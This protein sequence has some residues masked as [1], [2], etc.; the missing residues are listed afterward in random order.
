MPNILIIHVWVELLSYGH[1]KLII[2]FCVVTGLHDTSFIKS[3][4]SHA[5]YMTCA[6]IINCSRCTHLFGS[7][8]F[9][10]FIIHSWEIFFKHTPA[11]TLYSSCLQLVCVCE[12]VCLC[13][14]VCVCVHRVCQRKPQFFGESNISRLHWFWNKPL[15]SCVSSVLLPSLSG[16]S[17]HSSFPGRRVTFSELCS[18]CGAAIALRIHFFFFV[19]FLTL[20]DDT[21]GELRLGDENALNTSWILQ[22]SN[23]FSV[24][25]L[26]LWFG[27]LFLALDTQLKNVKVKLNLR[28]R[29]PQLKWQG[30]T[31]GSLKTCFKKNP[32]WCIQLVAMSPKSL[33]TSR[34]ENMTG[35]TRDTAFL[36]CLRHPTL[37]GISPLAF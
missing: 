20:P 35:R 6:L 28:L 34:W 14:C 37:K 23:P 12:W 30:E 27:C 17:T 15:R 32:V 26:R 2:C 36:S 7:Q 10:D 33:E 4:E 19:F 1:C 13:V 5:S 11:R 22:I 3:S 29:T 21:L 9:C 8:L 25:P 16:L 24:R 18:T 31:V